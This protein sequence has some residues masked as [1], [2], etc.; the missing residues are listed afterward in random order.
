MSEIRISPAAQVV[1]LVAV[2]LGVGALIAVQ[3]PEIQRY[4]KIKSM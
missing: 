4:L 3:L 2:V 1:A